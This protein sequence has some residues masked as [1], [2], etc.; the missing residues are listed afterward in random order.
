MTIIANK[1][2]NQAGGPVELAKQSAAKAW[3]N[4]NGGA[5]ILRQSFN[6]SSAIDLNIGHVELSFINAMRDAE[7]CSNSTCK[8]LVNS[9]Y[10]NNTKAECYGREASVVNVLTM[11][12]S[13]GNN[14]DCEH[15]NV[16]IA[17]DLAQ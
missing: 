1:I 12:S 14:Y 2:Q 8:Y 9:F 10:G 16:I 13:N 17:G 5:A 3:G 6:V 15:L 7:F 4:Y 11:S